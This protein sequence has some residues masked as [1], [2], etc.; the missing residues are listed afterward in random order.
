[1]IKRTNQVLAAVAAGAVLALAP[2]A[3]AADPEILLVHGHGDAEQGKDC[4]GGTW[5]NALRF[6]QDAGGRERSSLTT[7]GYYPGDK[8]RCDVMIG[9]GAASNERP[10]QGIARDL[11]TYIDV[12]YTSKGKPV[13]IVGHSMGG[14]IARAHCWARRRAGQASRPTSSTWTTS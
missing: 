5:R 6:F 7:I 13:D 2:A 4:N 14:L 11:A 9:D 3:F 1:V 8:G 10:I 12:E